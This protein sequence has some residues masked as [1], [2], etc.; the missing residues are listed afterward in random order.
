MPQLPQILRIHNYQD[1]HTWHAMRGDP[2]IGSLAAD[3]RHAAERH[4]V[5]ACKGI[6]ASQCACSLAVPIG[7]CPRGL[8]ISLP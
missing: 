8:R 1:W 7:I 6:D 4:T 5:H 2:G 3:L